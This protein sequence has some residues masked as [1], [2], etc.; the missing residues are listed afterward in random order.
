MELIV[1]CN[2]KFLAITYQNDFDGVTRR[3]NSLKKSNWT[4]NSWNFNPPSELPDRIMVTTYNPQ[5]REYSFPFVI[6]HIIL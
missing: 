6:S 5:K 2:S 1:Y 4:E 3:A